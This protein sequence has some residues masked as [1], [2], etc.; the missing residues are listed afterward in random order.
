M[1]AKKDEVRSLSFSASSGCLF[2]TEGVFLSG[3]V[4]SVLLHILEGRDR[5]SNS[6]MP[7]QMDSDRGCA[8]LLTVHDF[9]SLPPFPANFRLLDP[10][11]V[12]QKT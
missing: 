9:T 3:L 4:G 7:V 5:T 1:T 11:P 12:L 8:V 10:L 6:Q 2:R